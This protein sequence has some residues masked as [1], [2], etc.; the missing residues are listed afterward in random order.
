MRLRHFVVS[1]VVL[2]ASAGTAV[3]RQAAQQPSPLKRTLLQTQPLSVAGREGTTALAELIVGGTAP[4][5]THPGEEL[6]YVLEGTG[7]LLI[8][9]KPSRELKPGDAFFIPSGAVH[10]VRNTG[11]VPWKI[12]G[13]YFLEAGK[14]LA[15][16]VP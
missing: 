14:P 5:H 11:T 2:L 4:R 13:N 16:P 12:V 6:G 8:D 15:T 1:G 10:S 3:A 9:G 7:T